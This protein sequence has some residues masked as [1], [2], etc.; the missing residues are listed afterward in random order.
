MKEDVPTPVPPLFQPIP[1]AKEEPMSVEPQV[2]VKKYYG[3][4]REGQS[5]DYE[6]N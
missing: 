2:P 5:S 4:R 3:R 1:V 6:M